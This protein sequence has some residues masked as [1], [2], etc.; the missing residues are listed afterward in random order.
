MKPVQL[1]AA[2][3]ANSSHPTD[4]VYDPFCG[5]GTLV[6]AHQLERLGYG[7]EIDPGY[8]AVTLE[9]LAALGLKPRLE[10]A[11]ESPVAAD[12]NE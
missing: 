5:P 3:I 9:R 10:T 8:A 11:T 7:I 2:M 6:A 12:D 1:I 4:L